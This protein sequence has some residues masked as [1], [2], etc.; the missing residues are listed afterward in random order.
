[1][2]TES[3]CF[4]DPEA[5]MGNEFCLSALSKDLRGN[6][7]LDEIQDH[8]CERPRCITLRTLHDLT[9]EIVGTKCDSSLAKTLDG[10]INV[11]LFT[12]FDT[13]GEHRGVHAGDFQWESPGVVIT[14]RMSGVTNEGTHREPI[15]QCQRCDDV[16]ILEGRLCGQIIETKLEELYKCE[17]VAAYRIRFDASTKGGSGTV[18]GTIEGLIICPCR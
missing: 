8:E 18:A 4:D 17:I 14:G 16:G 15:G 12:A 11:R 13:D 10:K 1:M 3:L 6:L 2:A 9:A 7:R 5:I